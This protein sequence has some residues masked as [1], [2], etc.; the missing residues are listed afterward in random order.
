MLCIDRFNDGLW[1][2]Y[3]FFNMVGVVLYYKIMNKIK[4]NNLKYLNDVFV[5]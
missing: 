5:W 1:I 2:K 3:V 4:K